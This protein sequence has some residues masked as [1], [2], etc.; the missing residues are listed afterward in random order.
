MKTTKKTMQSKRMQYPCIECRKLKQWRV[1]NKNSLVITSS[2]VLGDGKPFWRN[3]RGVFLIG[4][5]RSSKRDGEGKCVITSSGNVGI[6][7]A[8]PA[9]VLQVR[10]AKRSKKKIKVEAKV[11]AKKGKNKKKR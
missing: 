5:G 6:G 11:K 3:S 9:A 7:V 4:T 2:K 1:R 8:T 10:K